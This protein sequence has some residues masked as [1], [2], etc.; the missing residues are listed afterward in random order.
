MARQTVWLEI[1]RSH[2]SGSLRIGKVVLPPQ[3]LFNEAIT[4][5]GQELG[6][7]GRLAADARKIAGEIDFS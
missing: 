2:A 6:L 5:F 1:G 3:E 7:S 4:W